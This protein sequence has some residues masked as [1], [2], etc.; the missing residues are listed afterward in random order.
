[1]NDISKIPDSHLTAFRKY[2]VN[3]CK[4]RLM[5]D[6]GKTEKMAQQEAVKRFATLKADENRYAQKLL[7]WHSATYQNGV[8]AKE[9]KSKAKAEEGEPSDK[10]KAASKPRK[11]KLDY[12]LPSGETIQMPKTTAKN[13]M[14]MEWHFTSDHRPLFRNA[15]T[16]EVTFTMPPEYFKAFMGD[17]LKEA[18]FAA[19]RRSRKAS[20]IAGPRHRNCYNHFITESSE[21]NDY[22]LY[23]NE[24]LPGCQ[25][26][27]PDD[28]SGKNRM[29]R[30]GAIWKKFTPEQREEWKRKADEWNAANV[31]E[32]AEEGKGKKR[33]AEDT[34][35][36]EEEAEGAAPDPPKKKTA[37]AEKAKVKAEDKA[38]PAKLSLFGDDDE[39]YI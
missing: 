25:D 23:P 9:S 4:E 24:K 11:S 31:G 29:K 37:L 12:V 14:P 3:G 36:D 38:P 32:P 2:Y 19:G 18:G 35:D 22:D 1:M 17:A 6:G 16:G 27:N 10:A 20:S 21:I 34:G 28:K 26:L 33:K 8:K 13:K 5:S 30:A 39:D 7:E 15:E